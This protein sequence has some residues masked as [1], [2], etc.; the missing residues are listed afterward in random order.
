MPRYSYERLSAQD[1]MFLMMERPNVHMHVAATMIFE[2]GPL[3]TETG[4]IDIDRYKRA[5]EAVL[6]RIPRYRQKLRWIPLA[7]RPVWVDDRHFNLDYHI[8]HRALPKPGNLRQ[9]KDLAAH[10]MSRQLDRSKPL[11]EM[12]VIEGLEG[13]RFAV[14]SKIHHCMVDGASGSDLATIL[15]SPSPDTEIS[16]PAPYYPRP[17]PS[18]T[19][20]VRDELLHTATLP[21]QA[22]RSIREFTE[23]FEDV[24]NELGKRARAL[25]E[26][27]RWGVVSASET[28]MNGPLS[29]HRRFD[30]LTTPL[31]QVKAARRAYDCTVNDIVLATVTGAFREYLIRRRVDPSELDFRISAPVSVRSAQDKGKLGNR[32]SSWIVQLPVGEE[33][34]KAQLDA[35]RSATQ[36][37]KNSEQAL[38]VD[39]I[40]KAAE[41][42]PAALMSLGAQ[43][44]S[45]PINS[46]VT[47]VPGPQF[48]LY[49]LGAK[50]VSMIP[51]VPLL[52]GVGLGI[53]LFSYD[54][55]LCWGFNADFE[56]V[57][58]VDEFRR[59]IERSL[60]RLCKAAGIGPSATK[61]KSNGSSKKRAAAKPK[62]DPETPTLSV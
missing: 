30:W 39:M 18:P 44:S 58:D 32:V 7:D 8:R 40:M 43:A 16:E 20:L 14:I 46:I 62:P 33:D 1:N 45:G 29:P 23:R 57:P 55:T 53:A 51:Q 35:I 50:L 36:D 3:R 17:A 37:L 59:D 11:W 48:P 25:G 52:D 27:V 41:Y 60:E 24:G 26:L 47:N 5:T 2:A 61:S 4:G 38:G 6:H 10:L 56:L 9:L 13:D 22:T 49:M 34:P 31:A 42:A 28:P 21:L 12:F 15:M 54:G 19:E